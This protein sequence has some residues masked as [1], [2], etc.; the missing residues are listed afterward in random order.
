M[1]SVV[2]P[3]GEA[4]VGPGEG[5]LDGQP[6]LP[7]RAAAETP[8]TPHTAPASTGIIATECAGCGF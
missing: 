8:A 1:F 5:A 6:D 7:K 3:Q 4:A 2:A